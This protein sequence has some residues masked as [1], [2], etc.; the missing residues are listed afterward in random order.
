MIS[1]YLSYAIP[2]RYRVAMSY[3]KL[4]LELYQEYM[5]VSDRV[6]YRNLDILIYDQR[7]VTISKASK[8]F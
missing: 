6:A 1:F 4:L 3:L 7:T 5:V 8:Q 2:D